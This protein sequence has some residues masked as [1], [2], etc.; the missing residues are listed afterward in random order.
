M[1]K[2]ERGCG[3]DASAEARP[4]TAPYVRLSA[5]TSFAW[6]WCGCCASRKASFT[7]S[8]FFSAA[9]APRWQTRRTR[10]R[11]SRA[12][13]PPEFWNTS[14]ERARPRGIFTRG[15]TR[16]PRDT[17][18]SDPS[19]IWTAAAGTHALRGLPA[20]KIRCGRNRPEVVSSSR[21]R[22]EAGV[23]LSARSWWR[24]CSMLRRWESRED[25]PQ[26]ERGLQSC[27]LARESERR[28]HLRDLGRARSGVGEARAS[29][30]RSG[31]ADAVGGLRPGCLWGL[32]EKGGVNVVCSRSEMLQ[33][34]ESASHTCVTTL[35]DGGERRL[36]KRTLG[37]WRRHALVIV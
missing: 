20:V 13:L 33:L 26:W 4:L 27:C 31:P 35:P 24:R 18:L 28:E 8:R 3:G 30:G 12:R 14:R 7:E 21:N 22:A 34:P 37:S 25:P 5:T 11:A 6:F 23:Q 10:Q 32:E 16:K 17:R 36:C 1:Q 29:W 19:P 9:M 15:G 2:A